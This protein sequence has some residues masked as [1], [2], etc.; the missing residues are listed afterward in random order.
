MDEATPHWRKVIGWAM[1]Q[2]VEQPKAEE[3]PS[4]RHNLSGM[5][6]AEGKKQT[7]RHPL[8]SYIRSR[9]QRFRPI[10]RSLFLFPEE[11]GGWEKPPERK[12]PFAPTTFKDTYGK[13]WKVWYSDNMDRKLMLAKIQHY[14]G[15]HVAYPQGNPQW[16]GFAR[17]LVAATHTMRGAT[18]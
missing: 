3:P 8:R 5:H 15:A 13:Y 4:H 12:G 9:C 6:L 11:H 10:L 14:K 2:G 16:T 18:L 1:R 7:G 17:P